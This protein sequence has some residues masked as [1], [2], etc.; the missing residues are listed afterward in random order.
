MVLDG[1]E[2]DD[3]S[4]DFPL[5]LLDS[6]LDLVSVLDFPMAVEQAVGRWVGSYGLW[7]LESGWG[8]GRRR[9][10]VFSWCYIV[11]VKGPGGGSLR[12]GNDGGMSII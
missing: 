10:R 8:V 9:N 5:K 7:R 1:E 4:L 12:T 3:S 2:K 6:L 11:F